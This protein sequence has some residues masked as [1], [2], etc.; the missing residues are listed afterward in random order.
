LLV[1][2]VAA[3]LCFAYCIEAKETHRKH[4]KAHDS[5]QKKH[6]QEI[7][8]K[9]EALLELEEEIE[10]EMDNE[11]DDPSAEALEQRMAA[12]EEAE[13]PEQEEAYQQFYGEIP[14]NPCLKVY[15]GAGR[16]CI[17]SDDGEGI[18]QCI[19]E[20]G[21]EIDERRMVCSNKNTTWD[22]DCE[23]YRQRCQCAEGLPGCK[24]S[25]NEHLHID[26]YGYCQEQKE[27]EA[28]ELD[29]FPRRMREW[30]FNIMRDMADRE[31]LSQH[32]ISMEKEAETDQNKKW[33]NAVVWKWCELDGH[34]RD[35]SVSRHE[36][37]PLR[38]PL[39]TLE[40]CISEFLDSCDPD[41]DHNITMKE[42]G[43]CLKLSEEN[44]DDLESLCE[45]IRDE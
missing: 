12:E 32:Y 35:S 8:Q 38:A 18:C 15:C 19:E 25:D 28:E 40:H 42:W 6:M 29:D 11:L 3:A 5:Q 45:D 39:F 1:F 36:L 33:T 23:L 24:S 10:S 34:P 9:L 2:L 16:E 14:Q 44:L 20:C 31:L 27:C 7:E 37:F 26:Y 43:A 22:N 4:K 41:D 30:L 21:G 17:I 13:L